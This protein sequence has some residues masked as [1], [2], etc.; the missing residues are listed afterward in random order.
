MYHLICRSLRTLKQYVKNKARP[1]GSIAEAFTANE[2]LTFCSM[3]LHGIET[4]FNRTIRNDDVIDSR[5]SNNNG[6]LPIF[7]LKARPTGHPR[8]K[9]LS[10]AELKKAHW[11]IL[12]NCEEV[13]PYR[14]YVMTLVNLFIGSKAYIKYLY[15]SLFLF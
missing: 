14:R 6:C 13:D 8:S 4:K 10:S 11:Y 2:A 3:Y 1:E 15:S 12:T 5:T 9:E 7:S